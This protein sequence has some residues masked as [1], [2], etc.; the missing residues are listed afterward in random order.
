MERG[1][2]IEIL[3]LDFRF[4]ILTINQLRIS[5]IFIF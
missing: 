5:N 1:K 4:F 2:S 3:Y